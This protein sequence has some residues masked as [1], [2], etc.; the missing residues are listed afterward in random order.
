MEVVI[1]NRILAGILDEFQKDFEIENYDESKAFEYLINYLVLAKIHIEA[2]DG[3]E[4]LKD[5]DVDKKGGN[6]GIDGFCLFINNIYVPRIDE[7]DS[8]LKTGTMHVKF[9]FIQSKTSSE[10]DSGDLL[11]AV[12][13]IKN[14]FS[15]EPKID[16]TPEMNKVKKIID[17]IYDKQTVRFLTSDSPIC[18]LYYATTSNNNVQ[19]ND[20]QGIVA[21]EE[22][23]IH[24]YFPDLKKFSIN[25]L[26][27]DNII[28][29]YREFNNRFEVEINFKNSISLEK[30]QNVN[31]AYIGYLSIVEFLKLLTNNDGGL[32]RNLFFE[33][34]RDFQGKDNS[35]NTDIAKSIENS[36]LQDKFVILNN[37]V[38][39]VAKKMQSLGSNDYKLSDYYIVNGCQTSSVIYNN[40]SKINEALWVP[41]KII[42]TNSDELITQIIKATNKQTPVPDEAF[43]A[44]EK[45]HKT[46]QEFYLHYSTQKKFK[47][48]YERRSKE[49]LN[50]EETVPKAR[51]INLH[52]QIRTFVSIMLG[53]PQLALSNNPSTILKEHTSKLFQHNHSHE[54]YYLSSLLFYKITYFFNKNEIPSIYNDFRYHI[55]W[56][57]RMIHF[58]SI[59]IRL[60]FDKE[61][62][63]KVDRL[64]EILLNDTESLSLFM[65]SIDVLK[66][67]IEFE[68][69]QS[70]KNSELNK[71]KKFRDTIKM[72]FLPNKPTIINK[73][74]QN[75]NGLKIVK[76]KGE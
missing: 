21:S 40:R 27:A 72:Y 45:F 48:Y 4:T 33:N 20:I 39:I 36:I 71:L 47:L 3:I 55:C 62:I 75:L 26:S 58:N 49:Y 22:K 18:E 15:N 60:T 24:H 69:D 7:I 51:V 25:I 28:D 65:K 16:L 53:E 32:R 46:L 59:D 70:A 44:L 57:A 23:A 14:V 37:G 31:Q 50:G 42:N 63:K 66:T 76:R 41:V 5:I 61:N 67:A 73:P 9:V 35:V 13:A 6:F 68:S 10:I 8:F 2:V 43:V 17:K 19:S 54:L 29:M 52:S 74:Q 64:I 30:I 38:T 34:V 56:I 1:N 11:K 12:T